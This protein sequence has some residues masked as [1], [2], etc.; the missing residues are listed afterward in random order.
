MVSPGDIEGGQPQTHLHRHDRA[1]A[2]NAWSERLKYRT[3]RCDIYT[4]GARAELISNLPPG[5]GGAFA[6]VVCSAWRL[7]ELLTT[8]T[9]GW[10][11]T[12]AQSGNF[13][14]ARDAQ[15]GA[16]LLAPFPLFACAPS[17]GLSSVVVCAVGM[18]RAA[19]AT[20]CSN[21][22]RAGQPLTDFSHPSGTRRLRRCLKAC[23]R[24]AHAAA[25]PRRRGTLFS[26]VS[27]VGRRAYRPTVCCPLTLPFL[28]AC[29]AM[30]RRRKPAQQ[31]N[32]WRR[33]MG[34]STRG[35]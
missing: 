22:F 1:V 11:S 31:H 14:L 30:V 20:S 7:T 25:L 29:P 26:H 12:D 3:T 32:R 27:C 9:C 4:P 5:T 16:F 21:L 23:D 13:L 34:G 2:D 28:S 10:W 17:C 18:D 8:S 15:S 33:V 35:G 24:S 19:S 6:N